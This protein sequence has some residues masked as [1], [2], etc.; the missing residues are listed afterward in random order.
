MTVEELSF[1]IEEVALFADELIC[2]DYANYMMQTLMS[3]SNFP[4]RYRI[5]EIIYEKIPFIACSKQGTFAL[6]QMV[7][8]MN[9]HEEFTLIS[10]CMA[11]NFFEV[12]TNPNGNHFLRKLLPMMPYYYNDAIFNQIF[13]NFVELINN[14]N[15]VCV[16]K[17]ILKVISSS[18]V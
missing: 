18:P 4:Q 14:K 9:T 3:L 1:F 11:L 6:Q 2:D 8:F 5:F 10:E 16:L 7:S 17:I 12:A 15:S 13:T